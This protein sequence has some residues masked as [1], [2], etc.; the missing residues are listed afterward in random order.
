MIKAA[1]ADVIAIYGSIPVG[2]TA[3]DGGLFFLDLGYLTDASYGE[4]SR[5]WPYT[6]IGVGDG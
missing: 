5:D 1:E 3:E 4:V 6:T 2:T